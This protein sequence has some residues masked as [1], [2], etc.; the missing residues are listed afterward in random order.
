MNM[1]QALDQAMAA[2]ASDPYVEAY[3]ELKSFWEAA[4][5]EELIVKTC[6][7]C[8]RTHWYPRFFCPFCSSQDTE[9]RAASGKGTIY[10]FSEVVRADPPYVLAYVRL[11]EG[12][13]LLTNIVDCEPNLL[14]IDQVVSVKFQAAQEG[15]RFPVFTPA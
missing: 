13:V 6:R 7:A 12:P 9:W 5:R 8:S 11:E 14:H 15:R 3:P 10:A 4:A 2:L 1:N